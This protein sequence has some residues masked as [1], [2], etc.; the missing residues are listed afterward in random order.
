MDELIVTEFVTLD[1]VAQAPGG[2]DEDR[3]GGFARATSP[4]RPMT[5][6]ASPEAT[7]EQSSRRCT[8]PKVPVGGI[9]GDTRP[10]GSRPALF[11]ADHPIS[12]PDPDGRVT[13]PTKLRHQGATLRP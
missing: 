13:R 2:P 3:E 8:A 7:N 12:R 9:S 11:G 10:G 5:F 4:S 1:G 6:S